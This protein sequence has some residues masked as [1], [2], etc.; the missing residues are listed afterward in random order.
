MASFPV[1]PS[2]IFT[3]LKGEWQIAVYGQCVGCGEVRTALVANDAV[4]WAHRIL[5]LRE[6]R[7]FRGKAFSVFFSELCVF[8]VFALRLLGS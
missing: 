4:R 8:A 6:L 1:N 3:A 7:A 2:L 5:P